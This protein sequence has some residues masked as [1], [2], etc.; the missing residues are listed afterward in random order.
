MIT[1]NINVEPAFE[2]VLDLYHNSGYFPIEDK[3]DIERL[4]K[5]IRNANLLVT[6][7]DNNMLVGLSR[8][9]CDFCY[10]CYLS[11][12]CVRNQ[13]KGF[14]IGRE[15]VKLTKETAGKECKLILQS[16]PSAMDFYKKIGMLQIESAFVINREK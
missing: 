1:Y 4:K 3:T 13:Y 11:D 6:A 10:C 7:W 16:N 12:L 9:L 14:G 5:M 15:L 8:S 2:Q